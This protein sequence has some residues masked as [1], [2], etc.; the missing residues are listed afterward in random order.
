MRGAV[1]QVDWPISRI[2]EFPLELASC[3]WIDVTGERL[4]E[5]RL[6]MHDRI[7]RRSIALV[8]VRKDDRYAPVVKPLVENLR[9]IVLVLRQSN[10]ER[11][12]IAKPVQLAHAMVKVVGPT[13]AK[14]RV[15][16]QYDVVGIDLE[17][18]MSTF[19]H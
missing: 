6:V 2:G 13:Q 17:P 3:V 7:N 8:K 1:D 18:A 9:M 10:F 14:Q 5:V 4:L 11:R 15:M 12:V 19:E 16:Q